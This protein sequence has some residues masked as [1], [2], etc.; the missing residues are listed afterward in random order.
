MTAAES[1][2]P[3]LAAWGEPRSKT[4]HWYDPMITAA[5]GRPLSGIDFPPRD[6]GWRDPAAADRRSLRHADPRGRGRPGGLRVRAG[7]VELAGIQ[8][9]SSGEVSTAQRV[10]AGP[11]PRPE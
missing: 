9:G 11:L 10:I 6:Q 7:R 8:Q 2:D 3:S 1:I 5:A 4:V